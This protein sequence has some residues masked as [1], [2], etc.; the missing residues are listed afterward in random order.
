MPS[1]SGA[2]LREM[3]GRIRRLRSS[4]RLGLESYPL[5]PSRASG[6]RPG[7]ACHWRYAVDRGEG[8]G[9][10]VDDRRGCGAP[11]R[12]AASVADQVG[13]YFPLP[14]VGRRR[15]GDGS[16]LFLARMWEPSTHALDRRHNR[17]ATSRGPGDLVGQGCSIG[18][19]SAPKSSSTIHGRV[20]THLD[21]EI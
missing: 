11:E 17:S 6:R 2:P 7:R 13:V 8:P 21:G 20:L 18:S 1:M 4:S 3:T 15:T 10:V 14:R 5:S 9:D 16:P 12:G 19:I